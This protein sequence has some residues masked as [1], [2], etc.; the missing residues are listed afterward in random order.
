MI[1]SLFMTL[2]PGLFLTILFGGDS[3]MRRRNI[4]AD[5]DPPINSSLFYTSKYAII[6]VWLA[7]IVHSWGVNLS[8]IEVP[9]IVKKI[10]LV[11]WTIGFGILLAGRFG[12]GDSFRIGSPRER[13]GL[14]KGGLFCISRN[15]MYL[16]V[17]STLVGA[18]LYTLNPVVLLLAIF[19]ITVHH[20]IVLAEEVFLLKTFGQEYQDYCGG[21]RRYI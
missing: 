8:P 10:G 6:V 20:K 9:L 17:F 7:V 15:P 11:I 3:L 1:E 21:V 18:V 4:Y 16:G 14:C 5:G 12:M 2:L 19:I 13:T